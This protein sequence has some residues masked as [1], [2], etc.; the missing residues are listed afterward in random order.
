MPSR[1]IAITM[2]AG[3]LGE[4]DRLVLEK[5]FP[6]RSRAIQQAVAASLERLGKRR[7]LRECRKLDPKQERLEAEMGLAE[8]SKEWPE[9]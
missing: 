5:I 3:I 7:L 4:V 6:N 1:K 8:D 2:D 9:Y